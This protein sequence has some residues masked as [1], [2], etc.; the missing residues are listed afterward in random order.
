MPRLLLFLSLP[1]AGRTCNH[2]Y[3][4]VSVPANVDNSKN[5][6]GELGVGYRMAMGEKQ[7]AEKS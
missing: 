6:F 5:I 7:G 1:S 3:R 2:N 4:A